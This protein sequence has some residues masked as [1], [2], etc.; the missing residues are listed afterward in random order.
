MTRPFNP[1]LCTKDASRPFPVIC[2][3][4]SLPQVLTIRPQSPSFSLK[5]ILK[6]PVV[7]CSESSGLVIRRCIHWTFCRVHCGYSVQRGERQPTSPRKGR[8][9]DPS[10]SEQPSPC[11][12]VLWPLQ[13]PGSALSAGRTG[14]VLSSEASPKSESVMLPGPFQ[15]LV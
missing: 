15:I 14:W 3:F 11:P 1:L 13:L 6:M 10:P 8:G 7:R 5:I 4:T 9:L 12:R 2:D